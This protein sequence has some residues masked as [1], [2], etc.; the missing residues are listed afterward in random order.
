MS[1]PKLCLF[2]K[3]NKILLVSFLV[4][5][6]FFLF[7][8]LNYL[9]WDFAAYVINARYL[10]ANGDYYEVYRAPMISLILGIFIFLGKASEYIYILIVSSLFFYSTILFSDSLY[11]N[12]FN[13]FRISKE[14]L[15]VIFYLSSLT[16][17]LLKFALVEGTELLALSFIQLFLGSL[18][19]GRLSGHFLGFAFLSRYNFLTFGIFLIFEKDYK[20]ILK[21]I[22]LFFLVTIPWFIFNYLRWGN[23]FVSFIDSYFLNV[24]SRQGMIESF[25]IFSLIYPI[26]YLLPLFILGLFAFFYFKS[27]KN[28]APLIILGTFILLIWEVYTIPFKIIRYMF[29]LILPVTFFSVLGLAFLIE[30][31]KK[32]KK[33]KEIFL[34]IL[35]ILF[36][37]SLISL[38]VVTY[39]QTSSEDIYKK[40]S[41]SIHK[42]GFEDC[43][44]RSNMWVP[45]NYYSRN[46]FFLGSIDEA[47]SQN[48]IVLILRGYTTVDDQFSLES[49]EQY[50][51]ILN[52]S[53][54]FLIGKE[55]L[56]N[57]TCA[58]RRGWDKPMVSDPCSIISDKFKTIKLD[59][60]ANK[61]CLLL[62]K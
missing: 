15:R 12:Y 20:K 57:E 49:L 19:S 58:K 34:S 40:S 2:W 52:E 44:I 23:P 32:V 47:I 56:T 38:S 60:I 17:F 45:I 9:G 35:L 33:I 28:K 48:E 27:W 11:K 14:Y 54:F 50:N 59:K 16:P 62:S 37:I 7:Q 51:T 25:S 13:K 21:N 26:N 8:H 29:N 55:G 18:I 39:T 36:I 1:F 4:S 24:V 3:N 30:K 42:N 6:I 10:F 43:T 53:R 31:L 61:S 22:G 46:I 5:T 41:D